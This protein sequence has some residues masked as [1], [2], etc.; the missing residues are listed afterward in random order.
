MPA[1]DLDGRVRDYGSIVS[2][3]ICSAMV[4][5][6]CTRVAMIASSPCISGEA[7]SAAVC[8][9]CRSVLKIGR[10]T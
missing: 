1:S 10:C 4:I 5:N 3:G 7:P 6:E 9:V 2:G 8:S